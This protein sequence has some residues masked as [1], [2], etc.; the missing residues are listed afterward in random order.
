MELVLKRAAEKMGTP[1]TQFGKIAAKVQKEERN[2]GAFRRL[3]PAAVLLVLVLVLCSVTTV[4]AYGR[5]KYGAW[6][7]ISTNSWWDVDRWAGKFDLELPE[8]FGESTLQNACKLY[9]CP[10]ETSFW[11]A[12]FDPAYV[13]FNVEFG[14]ERWEEGQ[15]NR[16]EDIDLVFGTTENELW[17]YHFSVNGEGKRELEGI[18]PNSAYSEVYGNVTLQVC[19]TSWED[20]WTGETIIRYY[21]YWTDA[22]RNVFINLGS[23]DV[24]DAASLVAY[25][26]QIVDLNP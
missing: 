9:L 3:R 22:E 1:H 19:A 25:A 13:S 11:E 10:P 26:K 5:M 12:A 8:K 14:V 2:N 17:K 4:R 20:E 16:Y 7:G 23:A 24:V 15:G 21:V 18:V 6:T